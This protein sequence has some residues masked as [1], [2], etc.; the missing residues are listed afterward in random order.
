MLHTLKLSVWA[1]T[2][3]IAEAIAGLGALRH[4]HIRIEKSMHGRNVARSCI[5]LERMEQEKAWNVLGSGKAVWTPRLRALHIE[6]AELGI[7]HLVGMLSGGRCLRELWL[8]HCKFIGREVWG[9]LKRRE[10]VALRVLG[11]ADY[12][13]ALD[14]GCL[15]VI[16][17]LRG[18]QVRWFLLLLFSRLY[19][20]GFG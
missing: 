7:E 16:E 17:S 14:E 3:P 4:L 18:L 11:L 6:D 13:C 5:A 2:P 20:L 19:R 1:L 8:S 10:C 12:G 15:D 9:F